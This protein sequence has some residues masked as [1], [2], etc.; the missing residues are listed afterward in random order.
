MLQKG[1]RQA[2]QNSMWSIPEQ[3]F[4]VLN[5]LGIPYFRSDIGS[6][7]NGLTNPQD[8]VT[9]QA[10]GRSLADGT[11]MTGQSGMISRTFMPRYR[12]MERVW[13]NVAGL[14]TTNVLI[15]GNTRQKLTWVDPEN[16]SPSIETETDY[17]GA[18]NLAAKCAGGKCSSFN[19]DVNRDADG[20]QVGGNIAYHYNDIDF[21]YT[22]PGISPHNAQILFKK[23]GSILPVTVRVGV[24]NGS[25]ATGEVHQLIASNAPADATIVLYGNIPYTPGDTN[26]ALQALIRAQAGR[27][28]ATVTGAI[29][30]SGG[31]TSGYTITGVTDGTY[32]GDYVEAAGTYLGEAYF[33]KGI[34]GTARYFYYNGTY[35]VLG[36][37]LGGAFNYFRA[38]G[39]TSPTTGAWTAS[40]GVAGAVPTSTTGITSGAV[41]NGTIIVTYTTANGDVGD[42]DGAPGA[43]WQG[44][45]STPFSTG[46]WAYTNVTLAY[47]LSAAD[48]ITALQGATGITTVTVTKTNGTAYSP[49]DPAYLVSVVTPANTKVSVVM[50]SGPKWQVQQKALGGNGLDVVYLEGPYLLSPHWSSYIAMDEADLAS[51]DMTLVPDDLGKGGDYH[52]VQSAVRHNFSMA[53]LWKGH[54]S[55]TG[56][57]HATDFVGGARTVAA[58]LVVPNDDSE[59]SDAY[60]LNGLQDGCLSPGF[61]LRRAF[62]CGGFEYIEDVYMGRSAEPGFTTVNDVWMR[63]FPFV[64]RRNPEGTGSL[65]VTLILPVL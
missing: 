16:F 41:A 24:N 6:D 32:N 51:I 37:T 62:R 53:D 43:G 38:A 18:E 35:Y 47:N 26:A 57:K 2:R 13:R 50:L 29:V 27:A 10:D 5:P 4:M 1:L 63:E 31:S 17:Y 33:V 22:V 20:G 59:G 61:W 7:G 54:Y 64:R 15:D 52:L 55:G 28:N 60:F 46:G 40:Y 65:R 11:A 34:G 23:N 36:D 49:T 12:L 14:P 56:L 42:I 25:A 48:I 21:G 3:E 44:I 9:M 8:W 39:G 30:V 58:S 19:I 45:V